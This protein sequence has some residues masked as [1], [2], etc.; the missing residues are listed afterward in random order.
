MKPT[1]VRGNITNPSDNTSVSAD[2]PE[3]GA[4]R[5]RS[6]G[7]RGAVRPQGELRAQD[8]AQARAALDVEG[9]EWVRLSKIEYLW[10]GGLGPCRNPWGGEKGGK[11][12]G[13]A[14]VHKKGKGFTLLIGG[15]RYEAFPPKAKTAA[16][17]EL[18]H[19]PA[20]GEGA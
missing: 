1:V 15:K 7:D 18:P 9:I 3:A 14:C 13:A 5:F 6:G 11:P 2:E 19:Q 12:A 4:G 10:A 17:R 20:P 16:Q 8:P